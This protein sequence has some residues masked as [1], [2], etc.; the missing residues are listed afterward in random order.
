MSATLTL[1]LIRTARGWAAVSDG[2][3][4][5]VCAFAAGL[6]REAHRRKESNMSWSKKKKR[7][8]SSFPA[9]FSIWRALRDKEFIFFTEPSLDVVASPTFFVLIS[10]QFNLRC[11]NL[12]IPAAAAPLYYLLKFFFF[13]FSN[14]YLS[15]VLFP[16]WISPHAW[17]CSYRLFCTPNPPTLPPFIFSAPL[18]TLAFTTFVFL[19]VFFYII[20]SCLSPCFEVQ[21]ST[22]GLV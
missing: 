3:M 8:P 4:L 17:K 20:S 14:L 1:F 16:Q 2:I 15:L 6:P 22:V 13:A 5:C 19:L 9:S 18:L 10:I 21:F 12:F 7:L 11:S